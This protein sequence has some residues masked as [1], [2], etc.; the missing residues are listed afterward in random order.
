MPTIKFDGS[1]Y[2]GRTA[3]VPWRLP[4]DPLECRGCGSSLVGRREAVRR[5]T[6]KGIRLITEI[7]RCRCGRGRHVKREVSATN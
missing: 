4:H 2:L 7:F 1:D 5:D 6:T 3:A